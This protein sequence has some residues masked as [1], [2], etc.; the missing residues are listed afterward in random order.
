MCKKRYSPT[1]YERDPEFRKM[2]FHNNSQG[3]KLQ[4][5]E[6]TNGIPVT[7]PCPKLGLLDCIIIE[8]NL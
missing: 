5:N 4:G 8:V 1:T 7:E 2:V 3:K 6:K